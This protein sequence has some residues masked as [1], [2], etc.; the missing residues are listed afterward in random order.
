MCIGSPPLFT[1]P[2]LDSE[3]RWLLD[4]KRDWSEYYQA[5]VMPYVDVN[6]RASG[7]VYLKVEQRRRLVGPGPLQNR[8]GTQI[9]LH[10]Y[11]EDIPLPNLAPPEIEQGPDPLATTIAIGIDNRRFEGTTNLVEAEDRAYVFDMLEKTDAFV[12]RGDPTVPSRWAVTN[13]TFRLARGECKTDDT[14]ARVWRCNAELE[15]RLPLGS[16]LNPAPDVE[17]GIG[18]L[19]KGLSDAGNGAMPE[20]AA[21][22]FP[23]P[24]VSTRRT[25]WQTILFSRPNGFPISFMSWNVRR[26]KYPR[27]AGDFSV[28]SDDD[29]GRFLA[30]YDVVAIQEGWNIKQVDRILEV[31]NQERATH[32]PPEPPFHKT[33]V[34]DFKI[35]AFRSLVQAMG[36]GLD[37]DL[38]LDQS[39]NGGLWIFSKYKIADQ[40][41][42]TF[43]DESHDACKAEDC[44]KAKGVQW[45]RLM[46]NPPSDTNSGPDCE[47]WE[48]V[49]TDQNPADVFEP[50]RGCDAP[51][52]GSQ[53]IDVFNTH[54]QAD[55]ELC[56]DIDHPWIV[57]AAG[58]VLDQVTADPGFDYLLSGL[59]T[60]IKGSLNCGKDTV[61]VRKDQLQRINEFI[62]DVMGDADR[63]SIIMGD[64]NINGRD[65]EETEY[66]QILESLKIGP[67]VG[68]ESPKSDSISPFPYD[69]TEDI[70]HGD[71]AREQV[72]DDIWGDGTCMGTYV[73]GS[74]DANCGDPSLPDPDPD[75]FNQSCAAFSG[76]YDGDQRFDYILIRPPIPPDRNQLDGS[77]I[78]FKMADPALDPVWSSPYPSLTASFQ[79]PPDRLSD[80]KPVV[81]G[82]YL[83]FTKYPPKYHSN[84]SHRAHFRVT[85]ANA[86]DKG[87]CSGAVD[88]F[89]VFDVRYRKLL[90]GDLTNVVSNV[91]GTTCKDKSVVS[92]AQDNECVWD[93]GHEF[94]HDPVFEYHD[95]PVQLFD[96]DTNWCGGDDSIYMASGDWAKMVMYWD[97]ASL[98]LIGYHQ[99]GLV[100]D[101]WDPVTDNEPIPLCTGDGLPRTCYQFNMTELPPGEQ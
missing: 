11:L 35:P 61:D 7:K 65:L 71:L 67:S 54:L 37:S 3:P 1:G 50:T 33:A 93:W 66:K 78:P 22:W 96:D 79:A 2:L 15:I 23:Q 53:Y 14:T 45:A 40:D 80:H 16:H 56:D 83:S 10:L 29:V 68:S 63:P 98:Q 86:G 88:M 94:K 57:F 74:Y 20:E 26:S 70:D 19:V 87:D 69:S 42:V 60:L 47:V 59:L 89:T 43:H 91:R 55:P 28:V 95:F 62:E 48:P 8:R 17:P 31:A 39:S 81:S 49:W 5:T 97:T 36:K 82:L 90:G 72:P 30:H 12:M 25:F 27:L 92:L 99:L 58:L 41:Y 52:S 34:V 76:K 32:L 77:V 4:G 9:F 38:G 46:L 44:F 100:Y 64:F 6:L 84:W 18:L 13:E 85:S 101:G 24:D 21:T 51:P 75:C 73:G